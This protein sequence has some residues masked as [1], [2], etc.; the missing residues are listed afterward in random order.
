MFGSLES[1]DRLL[2]T[3]ELKPQEISQYH[4]YKISA[5]RDAENYEAMYKELKNKKKTILDTTIWIEL[6]V[7]ASLHLDKKD[8]AEKLMS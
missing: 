5:Y 7:E 4:L 8:E 6:M 2:P 3:L 1:I